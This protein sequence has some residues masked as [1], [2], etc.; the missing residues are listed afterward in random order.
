MESYYN[1]PKA[2]FYLLTGDYRPIVVPLP[3]SLPGVASIS[4]HHEDAWV[5]NYD[6]SGWAPGI[7]N[8]FPNGFNKGPYILIFFKGF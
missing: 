7:C 8:I 3:S 5:C 2:I 6:Q 4:Q 1:V